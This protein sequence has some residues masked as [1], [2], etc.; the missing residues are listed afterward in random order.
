MDLLLLETSAD[1]SKI[2]GV[3]TDLHLKMII[4]ASTDFMLN[5][6]PCMGS[7]I[8]QGIFPRSKM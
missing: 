8:V 5:T 1:D 3:E 6:F 4:Y 7:F 2:D